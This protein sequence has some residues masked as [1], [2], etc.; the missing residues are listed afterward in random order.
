MCAPS[1]RAMMK[2]LLAGFATVLIACNGPGLTSIPLQPF[3][4]SIGLSKDGVKLDRIGGTPVADSVTI[5]MTNRGA[6]VA[7]LPTCGPTGTKVA[8]AVA[9]WGGTQWSVPQIP[10]VAMVTACRPGAINLA[11]GATLVYGYFLFD[12]GLYRVESRVALDSALTEARLATSNP[13]EIAAH[14]VP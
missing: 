13:V 10:A 12:K 9:R 5:R 7:Y 4:V 1:S 11:P 14:P 2:T 3:N 6:T 8:F